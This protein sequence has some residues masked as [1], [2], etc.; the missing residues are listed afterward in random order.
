MLGQPISMLIPQV[1]G[2]RLTGAML[3]GATATDLVLTITER[4]RKHGVVG[5][6]VEF[7]G[8]GLAASDDCRPRDARQ[9]VPGVRRDH[10]D[11]PDRR[12]DA[13]LPAPHRPRR[14]ARRAGRSVCEGAGP[15]PHGRRTPT[16]SIPKPSSSISERSNRASPDP[17]GRRIVCRSKQAKS[18]FQA[19]LAVDDDR[20]PKKGAEAGGSAHV[21]HDRRR[22][23]GRRRGPGGRHRDRPRRGRDRRDHQLHEHLEPERDD[24]RGSR[25]EEGCRTRPEAPAVGE[26]ESRAGSKV[27]TEYLR[28]AGLDTV[29]RRA[30][31][32]PRRLRLHDL[33]RQQRSAARRRVRGDRGAEPRRGVGVERQPQLRGAHPAAGARQLSRVAAARRR[34]RA[35][36][37]G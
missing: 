22:G 1:L 17:A 10:R 21:G 3:E 30:R 7:F 26:D 28:K 35:G 32:Q 23:R 19:A 33:H 6:F 12:H 13:R 4:L 11:F 2:F 9:H 29:S 24:R 37:A 20:S 18:G 36:R 31:L 27:V 34:L 14:R 16:Q 5:K 25:G 8:P 15:V